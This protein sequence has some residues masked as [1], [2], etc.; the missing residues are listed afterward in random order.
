[1]I[2]TTD[3][4]IT[5]AS[6]TYKE[7]LAF[8]DEWQKRLSKAQAEPVPDEALTRESIYSERIDRQR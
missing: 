5:A 2:T 7:R 3:K 1:M 8:F 6:M 4:E